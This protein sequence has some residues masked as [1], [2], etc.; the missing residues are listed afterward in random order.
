[1][2]LA[3]TFTILY[4]PVDG[5]ESEAPL[6]EATALLEHL[7]SCHSIKIH[8]PSGVE[9]FLGEY[10]EKYTLKEGITLG[11]E[12][13]QDDHKI[14]QSLHLKMLNGLLE[15]Q[16]MELKGGAITKGSLS[17]N[18]NEEVFI[19]EEVD[20]WD[21]L[22]DEID[23]KTQCL[24]CDG[25]SVDPEDCFVHMELEHGFNLKRHE[26]KPFGEESDSNPSFESDEIPDPK[27]WNRPEFYFPVYEE[28]PL[29]TAI[30]LADEQE[31]QEL[32]DDF[33]NKL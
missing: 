22:T 14:R 26:K 29:L 9:P 31:E 2:K 19:D 30:G 12:S 10:L 24:F 20:G 7:K 16:Q 8:E 3:S 15:T 4:C 18:K 1:M 27:L 6:K 25:I 23:A 32:I 28:D 11:S 21:D 5:C 17:S 13:D 33:D